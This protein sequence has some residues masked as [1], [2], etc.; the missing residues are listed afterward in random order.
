MMLLGRGGPEPAKSGSFLI[1]HRFRG[2][3]ISF[4]VNISILHTAYFRGKFYSLDMGLFTLTKLFS[5]LKTGH[6]DDT[7]TIIIII[8]KSTSI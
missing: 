7:I 1:F 3:V 6:V 8:I 4:F 2:N 5:Y